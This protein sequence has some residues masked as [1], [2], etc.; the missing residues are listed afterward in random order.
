MRERLFWLISDCSLGQSE[1][2]L[3]VC[4]KVDD[5]ENLAGPSI[6]NST[7]FFP[8]PFQTQP[9]SGRPPDEQ[10]HL[11]TQANGVS[12]HNQAGSLDT[13][14]N[15]NLTP[16]EQPSASIYSGQAVQQRSHPNQPP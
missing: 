6:A 10:P 15:K 9:I 5:D 13:N 8:A 12:A 2:A 11:L 1:L 3:Y 7:Q 14:S 16:I 4:P